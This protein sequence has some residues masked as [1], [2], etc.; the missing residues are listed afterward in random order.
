[1]NIQS[2][3]LLH[4]KASLTPDSPMNL[5]GSTFIQG[6]GVVPAEDMKAAM[7][8]FEDYLSDQQMAVLEL[9]RCEQWGP[10]NFLADTLENRQINRA[11]N[12]ALETNKIHYACG[13]SSEALNCEE[14]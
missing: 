4:H 5:D 8:I 7:A 1:M 12:N 3:W 10:Q 11:A 9:W 14:D 2:I 13:I 6:V